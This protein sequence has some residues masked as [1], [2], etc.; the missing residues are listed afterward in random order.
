MFNSLTKA[1]ID[2][3]HDN[4]HVKAWRWHWFEKGVEIDRNG[5]YK[6]TKGEKINV[7]KNDYL[8]HGVMPRGCEDL[9][10]EA[11]I[12]DYDLGSK[13][14]RGRTK[15]AAIDDLMGQLGY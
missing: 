9:L 12:G 14:G 5:H 1:P 7:E 3:V 6:T 11:T 4:Q 15:F 10:W 8:S 13:V 2:Y